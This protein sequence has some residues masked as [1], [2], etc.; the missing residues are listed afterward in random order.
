MTII[1]NIAKYIYRIISRLRLRAK[2]VHISHSAYFNHHTVFGGHN[3]IGE[4]SSV[5]EAVIGRYTYID[6]NCYLCDSTIGSFT[7]IA[8]DVK[9]EKWTHPS[10]GF[11]STSP[12]FY[13]SRN[14]CGKTFANKQLFNEELTIDGRSCLIGND[15]WIG[16][17][18]TIIGG[19]TI[20]DGAIVAAEALVNRNVP[21][22]A[23]VGGVPAK[24]IRYRYPAN[25]IK[26]LL[27]LQWWNKPD[28][29]LEANSC[30]FSDEES[31]FNKQI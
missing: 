15:V 11:I 30:L 29:W 13:S 24:V 4:K 20:G 25:R 31:F 28:D 23:A 2:D 14:Q 1:I 27:E 3:G 22:Y 8:H 17:G 6:A 9:I 18:V 16:C 7:S 5:S 19:V 10:R 26:E 21:P 12:V